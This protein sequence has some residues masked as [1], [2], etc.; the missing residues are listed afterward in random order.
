MVSDHIAATI[1]TSVQHQM[2]PPDDKQP[3]WNIKK[4]DWPRFKTLLTKPAKKPFPEHFTLKDMIDKI[5]DFNETARETIP[6]QHHNRKKVQID[7]PCARPLLRQVSQLT[8][9][10]KRTLL[11]K[12]KAELRRAKAMAK[13][14]IQYSKQPKKA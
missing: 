2:P 8:K 9:A 5:E 6:L 12:N 14:E 11:E 10:F 4:A 3:S 13:D 7:P 1:Y